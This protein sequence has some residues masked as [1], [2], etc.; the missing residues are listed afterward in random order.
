MSCE[1]RW[2]WRRESD[3]V[4]SS[5]RSSVRYVQLGV[6]G[7]IVFVFCQLRSRWGSRA[8]SIPVAEFTTVCEPHMLTPL[9][10]RF[11]E[12]ARQLQIFTCYFCPEV[13]DKAVFACKQ[14]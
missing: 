11:D 5:R 13:I 9:H 1:L 8:K 4:M 3:R 14:V 10:S 6:T 12:P 2:A 7:V